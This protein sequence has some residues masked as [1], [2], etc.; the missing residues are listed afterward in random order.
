MSFILKEAVLDS[1]PFDQF[2]SNQ[3]ETLIKI[4]D[5]LNDP[6]VKFVIV[7]APTGS[8]KSGLAVALGEAAE[9]SYILTSNKLLQNQY[10]RDF[11]DDIADLRGRANY[12]CK[13]HL[14]FNCAGSPCRNTK[15]GRSKC[16]TDW[17]CEYHNAISFAQDS[18]IVS[19]NTA[20]GISFLNYTIHL[21]ARKLLIVDEA[22]LLP[23]MLT[24]FVEF[25]I[26][27]RILEKLISSNSSHL[28]NIPNFEEIEKY[29]QW[30]S[31]LG[32]ELDYIE[33]NYSGPTAMDR[34]LG[35][36][37]TLEDVENL[38]RKLKKIVDEAELYGNNLVV[39]HKFNSLAKTI[40]E[41]VSFKP[42]DVSRYAFE[43]LFKFCEKTIMMSA[44][45][46]NVKELASSLGIKEDEMVFIDVPSTFPKENRPILRNYI[47]T[48]SKDNIDILMPKAIQAIE[49]ILEDHKDEKGII[50]AHSYK[51][52][53]KIYEALKSRFGSRIL[54][55]KNSSKQAEAMQDH[56]MSK[57]STVLLSP[58]MT[59][60]VD[61]K[62]DLSRFQIIFKVPYPNMGDKVVKARMKARPEWYGYKAL[63]TLIQAYGR[64]V[65]S[66][67]DYA[68]TYVLDGAFESLIGRYKKSLPEWF[69]S[70]IL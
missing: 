70:A 18:N 16:H 4:A 54:Y 37:F 57:K 14:G 27:S 1:F 13:T 22:H 41:S 5:A 56:A 51:N 34:S 63:L 64:S 9:S 47:G 7:Q 60:G 68:V 30:L 19:M 8:G 39:D 44:T 53:D 21:G 50:H 29:K 20:A 17:H 65:R 52:A 28:V 55:P 69:L 45:I 33:K 38:N 15:E 3:K 49:K 66:E 42:I 31:L 2:R 26:S 32:S 25:T 36:S 35:N 24:G 62:D 10:V 43:N 12:A 59:E 23:D 67:S 6:N 61:L 58:S 46:I 11:Q 40:V 48:L